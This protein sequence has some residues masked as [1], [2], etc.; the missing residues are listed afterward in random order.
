MGPWL[1]AW[2]R[3]VR[4]HLFPLVRLDRNDHYA[5]RWHRELVHAPRSGRG[6]GPMTRIVVGV[7]GG[8]S[9]TRVIVADE[10]GTEL[11]RA[12]GDP[13]AMRPGD[14]SQ[15]ATVIARVIADGLRA[16]GVAGTRPAGG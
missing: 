5:R 4:H 1:G 2:T 12:D 7:D 6:S 15:S 3:A 14:A 16:A 9:H 11:A 10:R 13:S 8:G